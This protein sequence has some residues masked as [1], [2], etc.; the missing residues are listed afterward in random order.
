SEDEDDDE[1]EDEEDESSD[2]DSADDEDEDRGAALAGAYNPA[3][4]DCLSVSTEIKELFEYIRR[5]TPQ[6]IELE[7]KLQPFIPDFIP[8]VGDID[9]FLKV[10]P[11]PDGNPDNLG[12]LVLDE[13]STKQSDP[14]VLSL[15]LTEDSK[16]HNITQQIKVKSIENAEKNPKAI[17]SWIESI[18]ELHRC[19]PPATVH[20]SRPMPDIETLM[21]EWLPEFEELL[22]KVSLPTAEINCSLAEYC[23]MICAILDIPVY[24]SRIQPLHVLFSLYSEFKNSQHFKALAEG[25]KA[26]SPPSNPASQAA[27]VEVLSLT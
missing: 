8:A 2:S 25:K 22:G 12:L 26:G 1:D 23:D 5:Y 17:D 21:Q 7:H 27:E 11:R 3:D 4:Y 19:K 20:Y 18:T 10:V 15:W 24:K 6:A 13:P 9:A 16:Q 14:T